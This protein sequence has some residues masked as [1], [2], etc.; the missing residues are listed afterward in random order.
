LGKALPSMVPD[1]FFGRQNLGAINHPIHYRRHVHRDDGEA[2][3]LCPEIDGFPE[4]NLEF[5]GIQRIVIVGCESRMRD[6]GR[7]MNSI[8]TGN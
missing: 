5:I 8:Y 7:T 2:I 1:P 4:H 3:E 6:Y